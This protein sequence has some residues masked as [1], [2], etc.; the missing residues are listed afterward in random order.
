M[1][2]LSALLTFW[3]AFALALIS[4]GPNFALMLRIGL[5]SGRPV[6]LRTVLGIAVGEAVWGCAAVFGVAA[7]AL[8]YPA[9]GAAI[10][11]G[12]GVFLLWLAL[13]ALRSAARA[14]PAA[15][16]SAWA[17]GGF[18]AGLAIMLLN[19]KAGFFWVSIT[20]VLLGAEIA[21]A[22]GALAILVA[23]LLSLAWH[24]F[25]AL[26]FSGATV[27]RL[28]ARARRGIEAVLGAAL[29]A[30]GLKLLAAG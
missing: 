12:G 14:E 16:A 11:W 24:T 17:A 6:A 5:G 15:P 28:Y 9:I 22:T 27:T 23:V 25:L 10:R 1:L 29:A 4:P 21:P 18:V 2:D 13:G 26:A 8:H 20:G 3:A 30:L 19:P 7:V